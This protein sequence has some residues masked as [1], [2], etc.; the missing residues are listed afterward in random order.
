[1]LLLM[2]LK[3]ETMEVRLEIYNPGKLINISEE[4]FWFSVNLPVC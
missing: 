1:M 4:T 3:C 2:D